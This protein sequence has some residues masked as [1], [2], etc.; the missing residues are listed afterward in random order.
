MMGDEVKNE[1]KSIESLSSQIDR[2]EK[3]NKEKAELLRREEE[4]SARQ[5]LGGKSD[6]GVQPSIPVEPTPAEYV[7]LVMSGKVKLTE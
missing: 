5:I 7:K 4:L 6:A 1:E 3:A 2:L